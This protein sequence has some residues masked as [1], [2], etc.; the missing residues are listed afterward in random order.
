MYI[1]L[2][3]VQKFFQLNLINGTLFEKRLLNTKCVLWCSLQLLS[4]SFLIL[5]RNERDMTKNVYRSAASKEIFF[6][7]SHNRHDYRKKDT[8]HKMYD[9]NFSTIFVWNISH[10]KKN[11]ARYDQKYI[12]FCCMYRKFSYII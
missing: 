10:S 9:L 5:R 3:Q 11:W 4:E 6:T 8:E 1:G 12:S 7:I 2:L